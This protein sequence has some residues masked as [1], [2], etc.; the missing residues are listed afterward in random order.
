MK[1]F[2]ISSDCHIKT[3]RS[4]ER[5]E[6]IGPMLL[7][8]KCNLYEIAF[9]SSLKFYHKSCW[10]KLR[11]IFCHLMNHLV[12]CNTWQKDAQNMHFLT[13]AL[14][15]RKY[16]WLRRI[17]V[18]SLSIRFII[19]MQIFNMTCLSIQAPLFSLQRLPVASKIHFPKIHRSV[20]RKITIDLLYF[21]DVYDVNLWEKKFGKSTA[22]SC[23]TNIFI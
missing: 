15:D 10:K 14:Y 19:S 21:W 4:L 13:M 3:R 1:T 6:N 12:L 7:A 5:K 2:K 20:L 8:L 16:A 18:N 22:Y 17:R 9:N 11:F 23:R